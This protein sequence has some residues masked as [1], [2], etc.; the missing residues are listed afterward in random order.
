MLAELAPVDLKSFDDLWAMNG[1]VAPAGEYPHALYNVPIPLP[2][3]YFGQ[4]AIYWRVTKTEDG[5]KREPILSTEAFHDQIRP[6]ASRVGHVITVHD[7]SRLPFL[8]D[9]LRSKRIDFDIWAGRDERT[10]ANTVTVTLLR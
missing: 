1:I 2:T 5:E 10:G 3:R 6:I 4:E 9:I 7:L 8:C